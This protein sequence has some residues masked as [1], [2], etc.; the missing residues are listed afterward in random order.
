MYVSANDDS[1]WPFLVKLGHVF[2]ALRAK[3]RKTPNTSSN[4]MNHHIKHA[5]LFRNLNINDKTTVCI[6]IYISYIN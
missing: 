2:Q 3:R 1:D 5:P 4:H 6:Y